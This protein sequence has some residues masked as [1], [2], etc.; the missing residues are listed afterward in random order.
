M[1]LFIQ[2]L[3][4]ISTLFVLIGY[5][6]NANGKPKQ[7][8]LIWLIGDIGWLFYDLYIFN[9]SHFA[10]SI[11]IMGINIYGIYR[12]LKNEKNN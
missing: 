7:A 9:W 5:Y 2:I 10:L 6:L 8:M 12:I 1:I 3:G 11:I 4:W